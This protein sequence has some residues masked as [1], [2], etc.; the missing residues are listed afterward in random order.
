MLPGRD[1]VVGGFDIKPHLLERQ[2]DF[3]PHIFTQVDRREI[4]VAT[5][6]VGFGGG[7]A[8]AALKQEELGLGS[9][10]HRKAFCGGQRDRPFQCRTGTAD[11]RRTVRVGD[12]ADHPAYALGRLIRPWK[13]LKGR[14]VRLEEHVR[15][16]DADEALN[17]RAVEH[18]PAVERLFEL[19]VWHL[20]VFDDTEDVGELKAHKP[21][22]LALRAGQERCLRVGFRHARDYANFSR[23]AR[24]RRGDAHMPGQGG[25]RKHGTTD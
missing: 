15:F 10:L 5:R 1:L 23:E 17:R 7:L 19:P 25:R 16:L 20:D 13:D 12:V 8:V 14:R 4:E 11:E 9:R 21:H 6:I 18:D 22:L 24:V 3:A 2:H